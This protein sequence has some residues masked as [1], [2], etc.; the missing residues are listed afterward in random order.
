MTIVECFERLRR[1]P[2]S[3][4]LDHWNWKAAVLSAS[5]R[6]A[7]FFTTNLTA[8]VDAAVQALTVDAI[9]RIPLVG[10]YAAATQAFAQAEP[11]WAASLMVIVIVPA[12]AHTAEL[13]VHFVARTPELRRSMLVSVAF[14]ALSSGFELFAMRRGVLVVGDDA[15]SF[16]ADL[17]RLPQLVADFA[18]A[19][20]MAAVRALRGAHSG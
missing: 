2:R 13:V 1:Q 16:G 15:R 18:I 11:P 7:I 6:G 20:P 14:S 9:F 17:R 3:V 5:M 8:G 4:F 19:L 12:I 10:L